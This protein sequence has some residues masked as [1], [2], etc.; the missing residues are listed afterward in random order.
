M[1][2][3]LSYFRSVLNLFGVVFSLVLGVS[4]GDFG[5]SI[6]ILF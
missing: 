2:L 1:I 3:S 4:T 5:L 6:N